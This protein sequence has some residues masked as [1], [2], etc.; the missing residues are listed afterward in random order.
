MRRNEDGRLVTAGFA[1]SVAHVDAIERKPLYHVRPGSRLLS[2]AAPGCTFR[3]DYCINYRLSQYGRLPAIGWT[4]QP[5]DVDALVDRARSEDLGIAFSYTEPALA[6][7]FTLAVA[8]PVRAAGH[9]VVWK[10]NGFLTARAIDAVS[11]TLDAVNIDIKAADETAHLGLT[12]ASLGPVLDAV[13]RFRANGVWVEVSTPLI[14]EVADTPAAWRRIAERIAA[15][16]RDVPWHLL[17]FTPQFRMARYPPTSPDHLRRARDAGHEAG[18]NYVYVER[19][20]GAPGRQTRCP[21]C[22]SVLVEREVWRTASLIV[23]DGACPS[24]GLAIAGLWS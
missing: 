10:T 15:V 16:D 17:R 19:A 24:C 6:I 11:P 13:E 2:L 8:G 21:R 20:L 1:L 5:P 23:Q 3:C 7:E 22:D 4:G 12:G 9:L 14:P 18:L